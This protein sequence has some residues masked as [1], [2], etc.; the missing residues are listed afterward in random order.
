MNWLQLTAEEQLNELDQLSHQLEVKG[1]VI[2]KHSTRCSISSMA[3]DRLE[4]SWNL[5][6]EI[7]VYFLDLIRY[8]ALSD[9]IARK[10]GVSHES[11]QI[12]VIKNG[13]CSYTTSHSDI[14]TQNIVSALK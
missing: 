1:V 2:F 11:P 13:K 8:R 14:S 12:L 6:D 3:L 4:R 10:Y 5:S 7:P 9:E